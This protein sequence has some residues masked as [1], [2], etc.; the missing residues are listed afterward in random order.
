MRRSEARR[1]MIDQYIISP[2]GTQ[3][4]RAHDGFMQSLLSWPMLNAEAAQVPAASAGGS[5]R[6][7]A[8]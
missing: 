2:A 3:I 7:R 1:D 8:A 5:C 6:F 4:R